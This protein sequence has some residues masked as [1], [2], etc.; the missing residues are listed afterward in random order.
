MKHDE[1]RTVRGYEL[2]NQNKKELTS[3]MEDYLEMIY[4]NIEQ[5]GYMRIN[6]LSELLNVKPSSATRMVQKLKEL[7]LINYEKYGIIFLSE[8]GKEYG[9]FLL[10]RHNVV[11]KFLKSL[12]IKENLLTETEL[13]EHNISKNT[14]ERINKLNEILEAHPEIIKEFENF[15]NR[16]NECK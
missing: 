15:N 16:K 14:M 5:E 12:G 2:L 6:T 9:R 1:F 11:E 4:R 10:E 8:D 7:G 3:A 13:V